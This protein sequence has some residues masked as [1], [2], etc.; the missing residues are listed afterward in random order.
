MAR[1]RDDDDR[2]DDETDDAPRRRVDLEAARRKVALPA[3][4]LILFGTVGFVLGL[5][6]LVG[7]VAAPDAIMNA[8][9]DA[10]QPIIEGQPPSKQRDE[11]LEQ[12]AQLRK[13]RMDTPL[14]LGLSAVSTAL[15]G[16]MAL[17]GLR[18]KGLKSYGLALTAS[19]AALLPCSGCLCFAL[20]FGLWALIVL[21]NGDVK[22]AFRA[23]R[24]GA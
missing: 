1:D 14:N 9:V 7:S 13:T 6:I 11:Q 17:G 18:M 21:L 15:A 8:Y 5:A 16:I 20:P 22:S 24:G 23:N 2:F 12:M 10:F 19:I 3:I 4:F